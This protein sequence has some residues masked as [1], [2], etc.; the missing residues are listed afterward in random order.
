MRR[1]YSTDVIVSRFKSP[2][3]VTDLKTI[4]P[5]TWLNDAVINMALRLIEE[6]SSCVRAPL[7]VIVYHI[8]FLPK[9]RD[10]DYRSVKKYGHTKVRNWNAQTAGTNRMRSI[11]D[12][13][14]L[15]VPVNI[16]VRS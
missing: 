13:D 9:Y 1:P 4:R 14:L 15:F 8:G 10:Q 3:T 7:K 6:R 16:G 2:I 12:F 11:F 5:D